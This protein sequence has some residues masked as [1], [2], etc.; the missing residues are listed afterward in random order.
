M[1]LLIWR[2]LLALLKPNRATWRIVL[3]LFKERVVLGL[4]SALSCHYAS[5]SALS[6]ACFD[7]AGRSKCSITSDTSVVCFSAMAFRAD[8]RR[9]CLWLLSDFEESIRFHFWWSSKL[10]NRLR[11]SKALISCCLAELASS[12]RA[13]DVACM[14]KQLLLS[15]C[16]WKGICWLFCGRSVILIVW[17]SSYLCRF[18]SENA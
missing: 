12:P 15:F 17:L 7:H 14:T 8:Q 11:C 18:V 1:L 13:C 4:M 6:I 10:P 5:F 16:K 9:D 3:W 2:D